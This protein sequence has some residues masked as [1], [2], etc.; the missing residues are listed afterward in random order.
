MSVPKAGGWIAGTVVVSLIGALAAWFLAIG[1]T[2]DAASQTR[3]EAQAQRDQNDITKLRIVKLKKQFA[4]LDNLKAQLAEMQLQVPTSYDMASYQRQVAGIAAT[5]QVVVTSMQMGLA[6]PVVGPVVD[7]AATTTTTDATAT[8]ADAATTTDGA[9]AAPP[10]KTT[11]VDGFYALS[12]GL[13]VVGTY[14]NVLA[15]LQDLQTGTQ[16]LLL[17]ESLSGSSLTNSTASGGRPATNPGDLE[18]VVTGSVYVLADTTP[19]PTVDKVPADA[20]PALPVPDAAKNPL[21]PLG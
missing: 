1:P 18:L 3:V 9:A 17:V 11:G 13:D 7:A 15:F 12:T 6:T 21:V 4:D 20:P 8:S 2:L 16:R 19:A 10:V 14:Q 5:H